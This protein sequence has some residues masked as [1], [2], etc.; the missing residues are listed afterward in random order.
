MKRVRN[1]CE[2][3]GKTKGPQAYNV[4]P[5]PDARAWKTKLALE[6]PISDRFGTGAVTREFV[7]CGPL[8][9]EHGAN[10]FNLRPSGSINGGSRAHLSSSSSIG[11][12]LSEATLEEA[13][14]DGTIVNEAVRPTV[15]SI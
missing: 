10:V 9:L 14:G 2:T 4:I 13:N 12:A 5:R 11:E 7:L 1:G 8:Q 6:S 3:A 15:G